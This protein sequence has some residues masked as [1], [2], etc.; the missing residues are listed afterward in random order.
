[1]SFFPEK[2]V[3]SYSQLTAFD[4]CPFSV[5][6]SKIERVPQIPNGFAEQGTLVHDLIDKWAKGEITA[7]ALP[8]EFKR[9]YPLEVVT[10]FPAML[11]A[12]GFG[13]KSYEQ[14]LSYFENFDCFE[15]Y[16]IIGTETQFRTEIDGR[17]FQ[18]IVDMVM[19]DKATDEL[20]VLDHKSK[21]LSSFKK[22]ED[23]MY[24]QQLIYSKYIYEKYGE[25]PAILMFNLFKSNV[26]MSRPFTMDAYEATLE[27]AAKTIHAIEDAELMDWLETKTPDFFCQEICSCRNECPNSKMKPKARK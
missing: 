12:K 2:H 10:D 27:W 19:R 23:E 26:K 18:G 11:E 16:E 1:M 4:S 17:P 24:R 22:E 8:S 25:Y 7:E 15:G 6:L 14:C 20:I 13:E 21:S 3:Y 5:Y 9:R